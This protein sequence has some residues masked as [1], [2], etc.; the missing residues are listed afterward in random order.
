MGQKLQLLDGT[1]YQA[2]HVD[3]GFDFLDVA[4]EASIAEIVLKIQGLI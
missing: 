4:K 2:L 3:G 1:L